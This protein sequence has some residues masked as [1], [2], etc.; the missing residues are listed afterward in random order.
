MESDPYIDEV[1]HATDM[2]RQNPEKNQ[3][4]VQKAIQAPILL[5]LRTQKKILKGM[6]TAQAEPQVKALG[7]G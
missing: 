6:N 1:V 4:M 5:R 7:I 3:Q 2:D